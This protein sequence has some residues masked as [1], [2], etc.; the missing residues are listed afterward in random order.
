MGMKTAILRRPTSI[1]AL[2]LALFAVLS[3]PQGGSAQVNPVSIDGT[4]AMGFALTANVSGLSDPDGLPD[5]AQ[6]YTYAWFRVSGGV[7]T[8]IPSATA[9]RY[10]P[11]LEDVG[12]EI[13][14]KV[15]YTD[16]ANN[17]EEGPFTAALVGPVP[18]S[19]HTYGLWSGTLT[20]GSSGTLSGYV[21]GSF[22]SIAPATFKAGE[23]THE[24]VGLGYDGGLFIALKPNIRSPFKML[25]GGD[26]T[27][28][29][30]SNATTSAGTGALEGATVYK[31]AGVSN[32]GWGDGHRIA[33]LLKTLH[34]STTGATGAPT[35]DGAVY[36]DR[37]LTANTSG[38]ADPNGLPDTFRYQWLRVDGPDET[39]IAGATSRT[40]MV[41]QDDMG[42]QLKVRVSFHDGGGYPEGP[43]TSAATEMVQAALAVMR[44]MVEM[45]DISLNS[46][47]DQPYGIWGNDTT[48]W[49]AE[50]STGTANK[51]FAYSR[52]TGAHDS[53]KDFG[54][55][56]AA[57]NTEPRGIWSNGTTIWVADDSTG[58]ANKLFAYTLSTGARDSSK[59]IDSLQ[60]AGNTDPRGIW[61][62]GTTMWVADSVDDKLYAYTLST[63]ARDSS[64]DFGTLVAAGN[65][66]ADGIWSDGTTMW[67]A[68][69]IDDKVYAYK[70]S[71]KS[72]DSAKDFELDADN[73]NPRGIWSDGS[74]MFVVDATD[75]KIYVY[76]PNR[77]ATGAPAITG[78]VALG[79]VLTAD[80]SGTSDADG[81]PSTAQGFT[82]QWQREVVDPSLFGR[83]LRQVTLHSDN[84]LPIGVWGNTDTVWLS[85]GTDDKI[86]AYNRSDWSRKTAQD[87]DTLAAAGNNA[88]RG[89]WSD[90]ATMFVVDA[91]DRKIFAYK[92]SD[93]SHASAKDITLDNDN[94]LPRG[95]WGNANT[96]WVVQNDPNDSSDTIFAY[97]RSDGAH[98]TA[99]DFTTLD[100]AGNNEP[101]GIWSDGTTMFVADAD[102]DKVYVYKMS[103]QSRVPGNDFD[104][105]SDNGLPQAIWS[106]GNMYVADATAHKVY[107]YAGPGYANITGATAP[108][109]YPSD[110]DAGKHIRVLVSFED[111]GGADEGPLA[112]AATIAVP[113]SS[114]IKVPWSAT[115]NVRG[116]GSGQDELTG[117][118][119][120]NYG[121]LS[122]AS[123]DLAGATHIIDGLFFTGNALWI[124]F[125]VDPKNPGTFTLL[126][127]S[128]GALASTAT[129]PH[130]MS[131][132]HLWPR[133]SSPWARGAKVAFA[134]KITNSAATGRPTIS[135]TATVGET[136][137]A[138]RG[139]IAD[140]NGLA[141]PP[142]NL[143]YQ[144]VRVDG[145]TEIDIPGAT[146][147]TYELQAEDVGKQIKVRL[148]FDD[149]A[150]FSEER[151][152]LAT[153]FIRGEP[154]DVANLGVL[155]TIT[156]HSDNGGATGI[157][158]DG[159]NTIWVGDAGD[160][161][162]YAYH[163][164]TRARDSS[165]DIAAHGHLLGI[166]SDGATIWAVR[167]N[168]GTSKLFA[169]N[170]LT[171]AH[172]ASKDV[173]CLDCSGN[174]RPE[175]VW[176]DGATIWISD[177]DHNK[178]YA[179]NL[180]TRSRDASK[181]F[182]TLHAAGNRDAEGIWSDGVTMWVADSGDDKVYAYKMSDKSRDPGK[183]FDLDDDNGSPRG[184]WSDGT[185]MFVV[186]I[187]DDKIYLYGP[188]GAPTDPDIVD[189]PITDPDPDPPGPVDPVVTVT[190]GPERTLVKN[191][192]QTFNASGS[193]L[194]AAFPV[195]AAG[196]TTGNN[197]AGYTLS[198][199]ALRT[200]TDVVSTNGLTVTLNESDTNNNSVPGTAV[201][202]LTKPAMTAEGGLTSF[203]APEECGT[204][205][206]NTTYFVVFA[207]G[208]S[209]TWSSLSFAL[210]GSDEDAGAASGWSIS[211][212]EVYQA[213]GSSD[214]TVGGSAPVIEVRG[215][216]ITR[217]VTVDPSH[218]ISRPRTGTEEIRR[219]PRS[220][221]AWEV[222]GGVEL[223]WLPPR[224]EADAVTGY[225]I[226]RRQAVWGQ[227]YSLLDPDT[228][229]TGTTHLDTTATQPVA[230]YEYR[231]VALR[232]TERSAWSRFASVFTSARPS[233]TGPLVRNTGQTPVATA[234][235]TQDY[236]LGFRLGKHGQGYALD[237]VRIDLAAAPSSLTV[238]LW[239][240]GVPGTTSSNGE[241]QLEIFEFTSP[242]SFQVGLNEFK[243]PPGAY[244]LPNVNYFIVLSDFGSSLSIRE[245]TS[246]NEDPGGE[247]GAIVF[248]SAKVRSGSTTGRWS[249][250][251]STRG[252]V[253][254]MALAG[255][256]R[257]RG[258]LTSNLAQPRTKGSQE[259]ISLGDECCFTWSLGKTSLILLR[260]VSVVADDSTSVG[261]FFGLPWNG[262][263]NS[264]VA[265]GNVAPAP[266]HLTVPAGI[267]EWVFPQGYHGAWNGSDFGMT[268]GSIT[269]DTGNTRGGVLLARIYCTDANPGVDTPS[270]GGRFGTLGD[271][272]CGTEEDAAPLMAVHGEELHTMVSNRGQ[273]NALY[274]A[275][276]TRAN[277]KVLT[278]GFTTG[279]NGS[280]YYFQGIGVN[281]EGSDD[282][283]GAAQIPDGPS[284]VSVAMHTDSNGKPGAKLFDLVSPDQYRATS[285]H[286]FEA[287][288]GAELEPNTSYVMVWRHLSGASHRLR[289]TESNGEDS[290]AL[291]GFSIANDLDIGAN[292][293]NVS[294]GQPDALEIAVYGGANAPLEPPT[295]QV[296][297]DWLHI[298]D[299]VEVGDQF[300]MLFVST[301]R[302]MRDATSDDV[303]YYNAHVQDLAAW[304]YNDR[305]IES[306]APEFQAVVCTGGNEGVDARDNT[307]MTDATG[308]PIHWL[309]GGWD[310]RPTLIAETYGEFYS[311]TW[312]NSEW[313]AYVFGNSTQLTANRE[314][315]TGCKADGT[316]HPDAHLGNSP[317][318][319][320]AVGTP[321]HPNANYGP[322][323]AVDTSKGFVSTDI[324]RS[325]AMYGISPIFIVVAGGRED[326]E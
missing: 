85:D 304:H 110:A 138:A 225:E 68:D 249:G 30:S 217:R 325:R 295:Y 234:S 46:L 190:L 95:V 124:E 62:D 9:P 13:K 312:K 211:N 33:F 71:D 270:P 198:S 50:N 161:K 272:T 133:S 74:S 244:A 179:Y 56:Q 182:N 322:L 210:T 220:L 49:V 55:L 317:M 248:N 135:D 21:K 104:L 169:Y 77:A 316:K 184:M 201:C 103:D 209:A 227:P 15:R 31:W 86:Y 19:D 12:K 292:P 215:R 245:T 162:L 127:G 142:G 259:I 284:S 233:A 255:S 219:A 141:N 315:W 218:I 97:K 147:S 193:V 326:E 37:E 241:A 232:G 224:E 121:S 174:G 207:R 1:V 158:S 159:V 58:T 130:I 196:F 254:R 64:K 151:T 39:E 70:M 319:S 246:D 307:K 156:L 7:E 236:A 279:P 18:A 237:N 288:P 145:G 160:N 93:K 32:P 67:V 157:W 102:D 92:M 313:G 153:A 11:S 171:G 253:L 176:S 143:A 54:A 88:P 16:K 281:I 239:R 301:W 166:W 65:G 266:K 283:E 14:L 300:R 119:A 6:G 298:P 4:A 69:G 105:D 310:D 280:G 154:L 318:R 61:S 118:R 214:W 24:V 134:I 101:T 73:D 28:L 152:S 261:G 268:I 277:N 109:Y 170:L 52:S 320:V 191:T 80:T 235:I 187:S 45:T 324:D 274:R 321:G 275:V 242:S 175:G 8:H 303:E 140:A 84:G 113:A 306:A 38:I 273:T 53:S 195:M 27:P 75:D 34:D 108:N 168:P 309:D 269:G 100:G 81:K 299:G 90:G 276:G 278:Q 76:T 230:R 78:T 189:P 305:I 308:V 167:S 297:K 20:A 116:T 144:W 139:G 286:F 51:L 181:E 285:Q 257:D 10:Y 129:N 89:I 2:T 204:L 205:A 311:G 126:H 47:N 265:Q 164:N 106:D 296:T 262:G 114:T 136:L 41:S 146:S 29:D 267:S 98:D 251:G 150:G 125:D 66:S 199:F 185:R 155:G 149:R 123:F 238:S 87:F 229:S 222:D 94:D 128:S 260:R 48:I 23:L 40:Y 258:I 231:V 3:M 252:S 240:G 177:S 192:G 165:K 264:F 183:D 178:I 43:L 5:D 42:K 36:V 302:A 212:G 250:T 323:G 115:M 163:W 208:S 91:A 25:Y 243:A 111:G 194:N 173:N 79:E 247:E 63:G 131:D 26:L 202:T 282:S 148:T 197:T 223:R 213:Q 132:S 228:G 107:I 203:A 226:L 263:N 122:P 289:T 120:S 96:I 206:A 22:G 57:G 72:H 82:Y 44:Q 99:K 271:V 180:S 290:G 59:D 83:F 294:T 35:I 60:A 314:F 137:T 216:V 186:D 172:A 17:P 291:S 221:S 293:N 112:S 200:A 256:Q 287:P 188:G 117:F